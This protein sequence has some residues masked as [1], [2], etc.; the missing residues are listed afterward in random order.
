MIVNISLYNKIIRRVFSR[1]YQELSTLE[2]KCDILDCNNEHEFEFENVKYCHM[3]HPEMDT[4]D[5]I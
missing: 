3:H 2:N 4:F 5:K 1:N